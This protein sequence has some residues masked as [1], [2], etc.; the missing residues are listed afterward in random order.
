MRRIDYR[1]IFEEIKPKS[2]VLDLGCG[3]GELLRLLKEKKDVNAKGV[4]IDRLLIAECIE[5]GVSVIHSDLEEGLKY[6]KNK[7][8][9][10]VI[11][12]QTLQAVKNSINLLNE[13]LRIGKIVIISFPNF[14]NWKTRSSFFFKGSLPK[15]ESLPYEWYNTPNLRLVTVKDFRKLCSEKDIKLLKEIH[16]KKTAKNE[17]KIYIFP[18][19]FA[20]N[21]IFMVK[22]K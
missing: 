19:T 8:F 7:S 17:R 22:K 13:A 20:T 9:D 11:I 12:N 3:D 16:Y 1:L 5:K 18:N 2:R 21:S 6:Y 4:E 10:Y 14:A 15:S